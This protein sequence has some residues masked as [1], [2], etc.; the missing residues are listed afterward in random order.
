MD[1]YWQLPLPREDGQQDSS[2]NEQD[3]CNDIVSTFDESVR[4]RMISSDV[5]VGAFLSGGIDSSLVVATMSQLSGS[6]VKTFSIGWEE[7]DFNELPL[8]GLVAGCANA[9]AAAST[10]TA[11]PTPAGARKTEATRRTKPSSRPQARLMVNGCK[12]RMVNAALRSPCRR[13]P[14]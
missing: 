4:L 3:V 1:R 13:F 14:C 11:A 8:A 6:P 7:K 2:L 12:T 10:A 5:P 9:Y